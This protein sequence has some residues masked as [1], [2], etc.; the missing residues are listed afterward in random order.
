MQT[1]LGQRRAL[2]QLQ[3]MLRS[4]R[5]HHAFVFH[6]PAGVGKFTTAMSLARILLCHSPQ[7]TLAGAVEACGHCPSCRAIDR[8]AHPDLHVV[9]KELARFSDDRDTRERKLLT[10]PFDVLREHLVEPVIRKPRLGRGKVF[11]VDEAELIDPHGQN[12]LLKTLEEPPGDE[13][14]GTHIILVTSS[15]DRLLPT[16]RS[17]CQRIAFVPLADEAVGDWLDRQDAKLTAAQRRWLIEFAAG[18]LGRAQIALAHGL[19]SWGQDVLPALEALAQGRADAA[20]DLGAVIAR[21]IDGFAEAWSSRDRQASKAAANRLGAAMMLAMIGQHAR[22]EL[23][24]RSARLDAAD[25]LAADAAL[26]PWLGAIDALRQAEENLAANVNLGLACDH[27]VSQ[28]QRRLAP[29]A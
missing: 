29:A 18:S 12:I 26:G 4:G 28:L 25:P 16:I 24:R 8:E 2:D 15:E 17:R 3:A 22:R 20:T 27:L 1:I 9:V 14:G 23:A 6:G 13:A 11:I 7:T 21:H 5:V 19:W 10:I